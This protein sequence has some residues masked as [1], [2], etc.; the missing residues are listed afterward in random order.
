MIILLLLSRQL[1][2]LSSSVL[3]FVKRKGV[4]IKPPWM[5]YISYDRVICKCHHYFKCRLLNI[6]H[7]DSAENKSGLC[8]Y[9]GATCVSCNLGV[10]ISVY[11]RLSLF[12]FAL[13]FVRQCFCLLFLFCNIVSG[14]ISIV[15]HSW[16]FILVQLVLYDSDS[17]KKPRAL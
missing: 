1:L 6:H 4:K 13:H 10:S 8:L 9:I 12:S 5:G 14:A 7:I 16:H 11:G 17:R 2:L 15:P 3:H